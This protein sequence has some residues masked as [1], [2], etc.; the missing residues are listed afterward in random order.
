MGIPEKTIAFLEDALGDR[1]LAGTLFRLAETAITF[2]LSLPMRDT[3]QKLGVMGAKLIVTLKLS[4]DHS[5]LPVSIIQP[6][7]SILT[8]GLAH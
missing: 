7:A 8:E 3:P 6:A 4:Q 5:L 1:L 2:P